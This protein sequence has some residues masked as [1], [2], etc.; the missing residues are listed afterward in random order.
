MASY[1]A[2]ELQEEFLDAI[3]KGQ[4][5]VIE[6]VRT[7]VDTVQSV[8]PA[9]PLV[10]MPFAEQLPKPEQVVAGTYDFAEKLLAIQRQFTEEWL[11]ATA[12][13][14][15]GSGRQKAEPEA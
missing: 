15:P 3:R 6:A 7:W 10:P 2:Q 13:L 5:T 8:T 14:V 9:V 4:E 1:P 11:K 12:P